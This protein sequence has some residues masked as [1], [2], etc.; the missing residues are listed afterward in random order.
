MQK[1]LGHGFYFQDWH[2]GYTFQTLTR[3]IT[4]T[5]VMNFVGVTGM[6]EELF[7]SREYLQNHTNYSGQLVPGALVFSIA[8]GLVVPA[9]IARTGIAYLGCEMSIAHPTFVGDTLYVRGKVVDI[10]PASKG[11]RA[12]VRTENEVV[13]QNDEVVLTYNPLRMMKGDPEFD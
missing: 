7:T 11:N 8:E 3:S 10:R 6:T 12:L 4:E 2:E 13:T 5:D 1:P 9:T